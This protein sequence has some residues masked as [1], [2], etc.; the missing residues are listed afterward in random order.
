MVRFRINAPSRISHEKKENEMMLLIVIKILYLYLTEVYNF[1]LR[2]SE[3]VIQNGCIYFY[4]ISCSLSHNALAIF[5]DSVR[6]AYFPGTTALI[7]A[8]IVLNMSH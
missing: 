7:L 3:N 1:E 8:A 2:F 6:A 5:P 4:F